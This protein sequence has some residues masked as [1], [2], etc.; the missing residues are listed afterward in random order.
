[1][2]NLATLAI[3]VTVGAGL[4]ASYNKTLLSAGK[5]SK[6]LRKQLA[7]TNTQLA[8]VGDVVKYRNTLDTL[9]RKQT[10]LGRTSERLE[11]GIR[12][13]ER[14]YR[15]AKR[16][17]KAYG[18]EVGRAAEAQKR[19]EKEARKTESRLR[20]LKGKKA[21]GERLGRMRAAGLAVS[22]A[23][24]GT[25]RLIGEA[26]NREEL[27]LHLANVIVADDKQAAVGRAIE[28]SRQF[29]GGTLATP[30]EMLEIQ[31]QLGSAGLDEEA[32]RAGAEVAHKA[33]TVTRGSAAAVAKVLG[34]VVNNLGGDLAEIGNVLTATQF[35]F[36]FDDF[37]V[38]GESFKEAASAA[39][40]F[41]LPLAPLSAA[42]GQLNNAG[43]E[44]GR[45]GT[46]LNAVLR[47]LSAASAELG[48]EVVRDNEGMLDL[49]ATLQQ[50]DDATAGLETQ[51]RADL[52]QEIFGDEGAAGA[53]LL[54]PVLDDLRAGILD[55]QDAAAGDLVSE[56]YR[57]FVEAASGQ[58][59][60]LVG[61]I[62]EAGI[63]FGASLVPALKKVLAPAADLLLWVGDA[64][65]KYPVLGE[66][67][68]MVALA[69]GGAVG[70][71]AL[72]TAATWLWNAALAAN[73][74]VWIGAVV[75]GL[76]LAIL[77]LWRNWGKVTEWIQTSAVRFLPPILAIRLMVRGAKLLWG[78]LSAVGEK[79]RWLWQRARGMPVV[80]KVLSL[81]G[82]GGGDAPLE[83][84]PS[85]IADETNSGAGAAGRRRR[86]GRRRPAPGDALPAPP[87]AG[88][89][90][91][92]DLSSLEMPDLS[93][94]EMPDLGSLSGAP[95]ARQTTVRVER[96]VIEVHAAPGMNADDVA[97]MIEQRLERMIRDAQRAADRAQDDG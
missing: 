35:R 39:I 56:R 81:F 94:L 65:Q 44:G 95:A 33:A 79:I 16:E 85:P 77:M 34:T 45:A 80:G 50:I 55:L 61:N 54:L 78:A 9:R 64:I 84:P 27:G 51:A 4:S 68:G 1:M 97:A 23:A 63:V 47:R 72:V 26:M 82:G 92:P 38:L 75:I 67:I 87:A 86:R 42:L 6:H 71:I 21:A 17:A 2:P 76:G 10:T 12:D 25:A 88:S 93:S 49:V 46:A 28:H 43:M 70:V 41:R 59:R 40:R 24:Y 73:P 11:R 20:G 8:A 30:E 53:G 90:E 31:Y 15:A 91:M 7:A 48:T 58:W 37:G 32:A 57:T 5:Q 18:I 96:P 60:I 83:T 3:G 36:A 89:L 74:V 52:L 66:T 13:V 14:R 62:R 29:A 69:I 22:G 19:L